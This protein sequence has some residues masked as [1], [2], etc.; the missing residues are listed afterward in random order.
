VQASDQTLRFALVGQDLPPNKDGERYSL[1][2]SKEDGTARLLGNVREPVGE[3]GMLTSAGPGNEDVDEFPEWFQ[4]YDT[5]LVT[6]D[7]QNAKEPG[8][9]IVSGE[10]PA[11]AG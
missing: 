7:E 8:R 9:V 3:N 2:F 11:A 1:W 4:T 10:L 6:E 5:V